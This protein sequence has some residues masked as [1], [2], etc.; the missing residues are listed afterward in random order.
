MTAT[1]TQ[2]AISVDELI[3]RANILFG[4]GALS[5]IDGLFSQ[6]YND[7]AWQREGD[8]PREQMRLGFFAGVAIGWDIARA[9][10]TRD[11][12]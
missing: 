9:Q 12:T 3:Q 2:T 5:G 1:Q 10:Y 8:K 4:A 11:A 6:W 7:Y